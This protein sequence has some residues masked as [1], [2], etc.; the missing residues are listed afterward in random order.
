MSNPYADPQPTA[1]SKP[2]PPPQPPGLVG[3]VRIV[4]VLMLVQGVLE[5]LMAIY[6]AVFGIFFGS[7]L[8]E[9]MM[10]NSGM[11]QAQ[12]PPPEL[13]SAIMTATPIVMGFFGFIVGVL[14]VYAGYR[15][16]LFQN[17]RL[18]IIALVGGMASIMTL[19][20][21]PTSFLLFIYGAIV[22]MNDSVV[23]AFAMTSEGYPPDAILVTFTGYRNNEQEKD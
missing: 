3:H 15:N 19:Y 9:A 5:L 21:C 23:T 22:Y 13:M 7:T 11:R 8:G 6:Y 16:F 12:G 14:H 20:C 18:G 10:E 1:P 4:A 17:R 2:L